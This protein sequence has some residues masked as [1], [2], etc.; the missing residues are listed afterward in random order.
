MV[1]EF[2]RTIAKR[3][4]ANPSAKETAEDPTEFQ[5]A[6]FSFR[7]LI[8]VGHKALRHCGRKRGAVTCFRD[9][10]HCTIVLCLANILPIRTEYCITNY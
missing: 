9:A 5:S 8:P 3:N 1:R 10:G 6:A 7:N 2:A 4:S